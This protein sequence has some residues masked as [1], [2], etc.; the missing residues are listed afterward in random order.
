MLISQQLLPAPAKHSLLTEPRLL[1]VFRSGLPKHE[2]ARPLSISEQTLLNGHGNSD[3]F[4]GLAC[5]LF[6]RWF[7]TF[8]RAIHSTTNTGRLTQ[9]L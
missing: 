4:S 8:L 7:I 5:N 6:R 3:Y 1:A 9:S 2:A